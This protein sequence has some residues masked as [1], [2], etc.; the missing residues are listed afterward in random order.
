MMMIK[1]EESTDDDR[2]ELPQSDGECEPAFKF[3]SF[4]PE[5][6]AHLVFKVGMM[7]DTVEMLRKAITEYSLRNRV[8]IKM[9]RNE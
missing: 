7:F 8:D 5:D 2:L 1:K 4:K 6:M 3:K 9:P